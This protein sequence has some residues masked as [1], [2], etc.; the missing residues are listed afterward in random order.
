MEHF[1]IFTYLSL[2]YSIGHTPF[3]S[4]SK[5]VP[6]DYGRAVPR[7]AFPDDVG[8]SGSPPEDSSH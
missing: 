5:L 7:G 4:F 1:L 8:L 3:I 2:F 6:G